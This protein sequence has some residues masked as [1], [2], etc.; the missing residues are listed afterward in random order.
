MKNRDNYKQEYVHLYIA[1]RR[2]KDNEDG[3]ELCFRQI[4]RDEKTDLNIIKEMIKKVSGNWRIHK[5]INKRCVKTAVR[6]L[7]KGLIENPEKAL[8]LM[9]DFK[10]QLMKPK[11]KAERNILL[12]ID[13]EEHCSMEQ[14]LD[15]LPKIDMLSDTYE[16]SKTPNGWHIK[17]PKFDTRIVEDVSF[18][19]IQRDGY[20]F[21]DLVTV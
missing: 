5:T 14:V 13:D 4:I 3:Q 10:T 11:A 19:T 2:R 6:E 9:S 21:V 1:L 7:Q 8:S 17:Y 20:I 18:L 15:K 12:D 16:I